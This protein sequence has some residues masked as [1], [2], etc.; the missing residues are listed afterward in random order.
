MRIYADGL[1]I[2]TVTLQLL[3]IYSSDA[4]VNGKN[5]EKYDRKFIQ[6][7]MIELIGPQQIQEGKRPDPYIIDFIRSKND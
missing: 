4:F 7:L 5:F 1:S 3:K 6:L 2:R